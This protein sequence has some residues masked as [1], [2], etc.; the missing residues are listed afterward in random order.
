MYTPRVVGV[1]VG[2]PLAIRNSDNTFHNVR[3]TLGD[4][5]LWNKPQPAHAPDLQPTIS[6]AADDIIELHCDVHAW[7][8]AYAVVSS[9]PFFAVTGDDG[10]FS[11]TGLPPGTYTLQSW[12]PVLGT[13]SVTVKVGQGAK[14]KVNAHLAYKS[15]DLP[16]GVAR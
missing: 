15:Q 4:K 7:M 14:G 8:H 16:A 2:Q 10:A 9:N 6:P 3:G 5:P 12:H 11:I 13:R 1:L